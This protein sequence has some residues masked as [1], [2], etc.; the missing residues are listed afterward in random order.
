MGTAGELVADTFQVPAHRRDVYHWLKLGF[1]DDGMPGRTVDGEVRPHPLYPTYVLLDL[2]RLWVLNGKQAKYREAAEIVADAALRRM[3]HVDDALIYFYEPDGGIGYLEH[4]YY[5]ALTQARY[6]KPLL[7]VARTF[8]RDDIRENTGRIFRGLEIP[9]SRGGVMLDRPYGPVLE[10]YPHAHPLYVLNGWTSAAVAILEYAERTHDQEATEFGRANVAAM[11]S[12][13]EKFDVPE[14]AN[15]RYGLASYTWLRLS[16]SENDEQSNV[17]MLNGAVTIPDDGTFP[18]AT[19]TTNRYS[20]WFDPNRVG[21]DGRLV[22]RT[23][24]MNVLLSN[25]NDENSLSVTFSLE[26]PAA[27]TFQLPVGEYDP[28]SSS[29]RVTG[30]KDA[31]K[32]DL[33]PGTHTLRLSIPM[34]ELPLIGYPTNFKKLISGRRHNAYHFI[35]IRNMQHLLK[36]A[37]D[38]RMVD[39]LVRWAEYLA[40]WRDIPAYQDERISLSHIPNGHASAFPFEGAPGPRE[41]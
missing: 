24:Q 17:R 8:G 32:A 29:M 13:I 28:M 6:L 5:S 2:M 31:E 36:L 10:E 26:R 34:S 23:A 39:W 15:S 33:E 35:H 11:L 3:T 37:P 4:R 12:L 21:Q 7:D 27:V 41:R 16:F 20:N 19:D 9:S 1:T 40:R 18:F 38:P 22:K 25:I 14:L 30:W